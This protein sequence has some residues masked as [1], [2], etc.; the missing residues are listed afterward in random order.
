VTAS[1]GLAV[2]LLAS[3]VA[4]ACGSPS[5]SADTTD[6]TPKTIVKPAPEPGATVREP[7]P[8][9]VAALERAAYAV[10]D[11]DSGRTLAEQRPEQIDTPVWPGSIAK[12][13]TLA[14]ALE[15]GTLTA[16]TRIA[17]TRHVRLADGRDVDC[18]HPP[19]DHP[20]SVV[21]ALTWSCNV[22]T[23]TVARGLTP[24]ALAGGFV[25]FGLA[26]P[27]A[28]ADPVAAALGLAGH[29]ATPRALLALLRRVVVSR[30]SGDER[31]DDG[32]MSVVREGLRGSAREGTSA[33][34][35]EL[36]IDAL[37]KTGTA[38][39]P[40]GRPLGLVVAAWP[41]TAPR[42][43]V[44]LALP[45]GSGAQAAEVAAVLAQRRIRA[46]SSRSTGSQAAPSASRPDV[47]RSE[48]ATSPAGS[49]PVMGTS[50]T[51]GAA[52][53]DGDSTHSRPTVLRIGTPTSSGYRVE[54]MPLEDYV[55]AVVSGETSS[56]TPD[57]ARET[58]AITARTYALVNRHRHADEGFDLCTLTHCQVVRP[59][60][61]ESRRAAI[62]TQGQ[63]L[64][65]ADPDN[66]MT[67]PP[68]GPPV[69]ASRL[70]AVRSR[71]AGSTSAT[72]L[73]PVFYSASCGGQLEDAS[74]L[75][76]NVP[77]GS[78]P[79]LT[80]RPSARPDRAAD[81]ERRDLARLA[82]RARPVLDFRGRFPPHSRSPPRLGSAREPAIH[83][84]AHGQ[85]LSLHRSRARTRRRSLCLRRIGHGATRRIRRENPGDV[86]SGTEDFSGIEGCGGAARHGHRGG[87]RGVEAGAGDH[88]VSDRLG[89][90][91]RASDRD[92]V[93]PAGGGGR[94]ARRAACAARSH[95]ARS[96][97]R[98]GRA[99]A[100]GDRG[101]RVSDRR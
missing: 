66:A 12:I 37:A 35:G 51:R 68:A 18:S 31:I 101:H 32:A 78:L 40:N 88:A 75:L 10:I 9:A 2:C 54:S 87:C 26:P 55:A 99:A 49:S 69:A 56:A 23:A 93:D 34:F 30:G 15:A 39:M 67:A 6:T 36:D 85:R 7:D 90:S 19:L 74:V 43:A 96:G 22:F 20:L 83:G 11:V 95:G 44:V 100:R 58:L 84:D 53:S 17:C 86:F 72:S 52:V 27:P 13:A 62:R 89:A 4:T 29:K 64:L 14:G 91:Y 61:L 25:R 8:A 41:S 73:A 16:D 50:R 81:A 24:S 60:T 71:A 97:R 46:A 92:R 42:E 21:D 33:A 38:L 82:G 77:R 65:R 28:T 1:A 76:P 47:D 45:G 5:P 48:A 70:R 63:V 59:A 94:R 80:A 79:W 57:A 98:D 3:L